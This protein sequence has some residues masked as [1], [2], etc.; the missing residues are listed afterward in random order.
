[1]IPKKCRR[2]TEVN[3]PIAVGGE[4]PCAN[5]YAGQYRKTCAAILGA[6]L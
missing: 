5:P 4:Q 1:M 6:S 3:S 2:L